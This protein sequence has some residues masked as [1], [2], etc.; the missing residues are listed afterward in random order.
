MVEIVIVLWM[1]WLIATDV[2]YAAKGQ[3]PPRK[4]V[5]LAEIEAG[6]AQ[7]RYGVRGWA[8]D[9]F[10][11]ALKAKTER[12]R[13][14]AAERKDAK[15]ADEVEFDLI[16]HFDTL[17][18]QRDPLPAPT[19]A[20]PTDTGP[21]SDVGYRKPQPGERAPDNMTG[22]VMEWTGS[23]WAPVC[24]VDDIPM[25][26]RDDEGWLTCERCGRRPFDPQP[27]QPTSTN[28]PLASVIPMFPTSTEKEHSMSDQ[29]VAEVT[30]LQSAIA[31]AEGVSGAHAAHGAAEGFTA[32]LADAGYGDS[33]LGAVA[34]A[35]EA[36][37]NA[38]ALWAAAAAK[39]KESNVVKEAYDNVPDAGNKHHV[40]AE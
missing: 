6:D 33:V 5:R 3:V 2:I 10:D 27:E 30:G 13:E 40:M 4:Q 24:P 23:Q 36:S 22:R 35:Q 15:R 7:S 21:D 37:A 29:P 34:A 20:V 11:D 31:Y 12:R 19:V 26:G 9:L 32:S 38:G 39:L 25:G 1:A 14:K 28:E 17:P 8:R 18:Y 16:D